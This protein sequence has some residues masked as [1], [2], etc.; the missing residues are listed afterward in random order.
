MPL[1]VEL[2]TL[3][4][5]VRLIVID[6]LAGI[7]KIAAGTTQRSRANSEKYLRLSKSSKMLRGTKQKG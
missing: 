1:L 5:I 3:I 7:T 2:G 4:M 6:F